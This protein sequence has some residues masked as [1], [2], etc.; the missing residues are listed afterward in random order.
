MTD[1]CW[2]PCV[3]VLRDDAVPYYSRRQLAVRPDFLE[4]VCSPAKQY[5]LSVA[6]CCLIEINLQFVGEGFKASDPSSTNESRSYQHSVRRS[7]R[8]Y[9]RNT[10]SLSLLQETTRL[11]SYRTN[12]GLASSQLSLL[13]PDLQISKAFCSSSIADDSLLGRSRNAFSIWQVTPLVR[14]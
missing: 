2:A 3:S 13:Y 12:W 8:E 14:R 7:F 6:S 11:F 5:P 9:D 1:E 10:S 4:D